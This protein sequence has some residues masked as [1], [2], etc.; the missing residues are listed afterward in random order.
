MSSTLPGTPLI[1]ALRRKV[2]TLEDD[3]DRL[4]QENSELRERV[5]ELEH[6][7]PTVEEK[8]YC[9]LEKSEK[10]KILRDKLRETAT[11]TNGKAS[12]GYKGVMALWNGRPSVGHAYDIMRTAGMMEQ[13]EYGDGR[14]GKKRVTID[15]T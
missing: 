3:L 7:A 11:A 2:N 8:E 4:E 15:L 5:E 9:D 13:T 12:L 14:N 1:E 6:R 10:V